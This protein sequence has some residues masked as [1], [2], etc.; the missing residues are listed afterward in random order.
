M[1]PLAAPHEPDTKVNYWFVTAALTETTRSEW[2]RLR[3]PSGAPQQNANIATWD[4]LL[5]RCSSSGEAAN[6]FTMEN[7]AARGFR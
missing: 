1:A 6:R 2:L 5:Q 7:E 4:D 3:S